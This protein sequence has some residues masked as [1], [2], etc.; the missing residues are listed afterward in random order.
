MATI[1]FSQPLSGLVVD[2]WIE[3]VPSAS[4]TTAIAFQFDPPD[5]C[6]PQCLLLAVPPVPGAEWTADTLLQVLDETRD[7]AKLR[8][9]DIEALG[10]TAQYLPALC[11]AFNAKDAAVSTDFA[12]LT[13]S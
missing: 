11:L 7:L 3:I 10:E 4:E 2:E 5:V 8:A 6:A 12:P 9:V 13:R 1:N